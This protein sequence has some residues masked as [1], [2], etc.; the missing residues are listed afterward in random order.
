MAA[1]LKLIEPSTVSRLSKQQR[2]YFIWLDL[3]ISIK[4]NAKIV[5]I[6]QINIC[7]PSL[8]CSETIK[9]LISV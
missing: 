9:G 6:K 2:N 3:K 4:I 7:K 1:S 8:G 5:K